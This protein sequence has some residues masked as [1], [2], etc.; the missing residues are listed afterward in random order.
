LEFE[1]QFRIE[2]AYSLISF[3]ITFSIICRPL[4]GS[5]GTPC[6]PEKKPTFFGHFVIDKARH[7]MPREMVFTLS[8][9]LSLSLSHTHKHTHTHTHTQANTCLQVKSFDS[10]VVFFVA[11]PFIY[12]FGWFYCSER[13]CIYFT[14]FS[15]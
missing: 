2:N 12:V 15:A 9:S 10:E 3:P 6:F 1:E 7:Q 4:V 11:L 14:L 5:I 8:L 13:S